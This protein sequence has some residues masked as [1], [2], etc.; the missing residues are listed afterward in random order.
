MNTQMSV[1]ENSDGPA[2]M[3]GKKTG[4]IAHLKRYNDSVIH[5]HC[6]N[7][8]LQLAVSKAFKSIT[9][10]NNTDELLTGPFKYYHYSTVRSESLNAIQNL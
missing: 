10:M 6:L 3:V 8:R 4:L 9:I 7:H 2:V 5:L 1:R